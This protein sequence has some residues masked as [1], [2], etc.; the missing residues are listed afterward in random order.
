MAP[1]HRQNNVVRNY[2]DADQQ[3]LAAAMR[4][5]WASF[6]ASGDPSTVAVPW[7][8]FDASAQVV[9][10]MT[11]RPQVSTTFASRHHCSLWA[12]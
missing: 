12:G 10:L 9:S 2:S 7:P 3:A 8:S 1:P 5:A 4:A 11:P 6:A